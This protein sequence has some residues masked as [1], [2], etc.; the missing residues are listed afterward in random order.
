MAQRDWAHGSTAHGSSHQ[1]RARAVP[2][3]SQVLEWRLDLSKILKCFATVERGDEPAGQRCMH[4]RGQELIH[5]TT[6][7]PPYCEGMPD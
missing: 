7:P 2:P 6:T 5:S 4:V 3:G 1:A